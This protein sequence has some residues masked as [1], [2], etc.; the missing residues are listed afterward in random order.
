M[1][2]LTSRTALQVNAVMALIATA[3]AAAIMILAVTEPVTFAAA[4]AQHEYGA[5]AV[6]VAREVTG[7]LLALLRFL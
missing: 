3:A 5:V 7:W 1:T 2:A 6:A 4:F